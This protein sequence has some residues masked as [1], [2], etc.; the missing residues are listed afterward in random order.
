MAVGERLTGI[1]IQIMDILTHLA[2]NRIKE[3]NIIIHHGT[4]GYLV[5]FVVHIFI[6]AHG[7][8]LT[9]VQIIITM[10]VFL[11][12]GKTAKTEINI[13][14]IR[15]GTVD[16]HLISVERIFIMGVGTLV[17]EILDRIKMLIHEVGNKIK[18]NITIIQGGIVGC[19]VILM[20]DIFIM[21]NGLM[22]IILVKEDKVLT[23]EKHLKIECGRQI[24]T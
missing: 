16:F 13:T 15:L 17:M 7:I 9:E 10:E 12:D 11:Q 22:K 8:L 21:V 19:R 23:L 24:Y 4:V 2:G 18:E 5:I 14:T 6:M 20:V 1:L 3:N